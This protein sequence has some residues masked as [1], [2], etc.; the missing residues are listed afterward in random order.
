M[1]TSSVISSF[2][3]YLGETR[4]CLRV[5]GVDK[6]S[7]KQG[8]RWSETKARSPNIKNFPKLDLTGNDRE[9]MTTKYEETQEDKQEHENEEGSSEKSKRKKSDSS[10][11]G[12]TP[13]KRIILKIGCEIVKE[14]NEA[15]DQETNPSTSSPKDKQRK[16]SDKEK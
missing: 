14:I 11:E 12:R 4:P 13:R 16:D 7:A 9:W 3:V 10:Q 2:N 1:K 6:S 15:E 5:L 8:K